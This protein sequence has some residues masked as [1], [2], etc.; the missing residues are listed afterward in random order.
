MKKRLEDQVVIVTGG[1]SGL[2][3]AVVKRFVRDGARVVVL[4]RNQSRIDEL[5]RDA[6]AEVSYCLGDVRD[7]AANQAAVEHALE[8]YGRLDCVIG[9]AGIWDY[10]LPL[11]DTEDDQLA[12]G[13]TELFETNVLGYMNL[14]KAALKPLAASK[15]SMIFTVSNAG[16]Y[17]NGGGVLY[18]ATKHAVVG[19]IRQMAYE[20]APHI[21][22]NG[23]APGAIPTNLSGAETLGLGSREFPGDRLRENAPESIP[24][25]R[26]NEVEEY[27]GAF[28]FF[29]SREDHLPATGS[30]L[31][32]DGGFG[33][34][35]LGGR[36]R[37]GDRLLEKLGLGV[38]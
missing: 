14:A 30:I 19:F 37:G 26:L 36:L 34:R 16:F 9:N 17:P 3:K 1:G 20:L 6:P 12:P 11:V 38:D 13:F 24:L 5:E 22:V 10:S 28:V 21:R 18:T 31:N 23:V 2:G 32:H 33:I 27:A 4:D 8:R 35:G 7:L 15:G 29:A 25:A